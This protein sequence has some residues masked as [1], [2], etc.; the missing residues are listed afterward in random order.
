MFL[1]KK[2]KTV[3]ALSLFLCSNL[4][5]QTDNETSNT[6]TSFENSN[7]TTELRAITVKSSKDVTGG[8]QLIR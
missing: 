4:F 3:F 1:S 2:Q 5:A 8:G 7:E 6:I